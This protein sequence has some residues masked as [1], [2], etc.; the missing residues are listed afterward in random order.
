MNYPPDWRSRVQT[1]PWWV[2]RY[3]TRQNAL[4]H[5]IRT[6]EQEGP[7]LAPMWHILSSH[8][9]PIHW[10]V[11]AQRVVT[12]VSI[13]PKTFPKTMY[14]D[15][16]GWHDGDTDE[17]VADNWTDSDWTNSD[18]TDSDWTEDY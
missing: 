13:I 2:H 4:K 10:P 11:S 5:L 12:L 16:D 1:T 7:L 14:R 3:G 8:A 9:R 15:T 18:W 6:G 17:D